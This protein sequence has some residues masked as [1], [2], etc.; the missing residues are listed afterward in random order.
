MRQGRKTLVGL[1]F[2]AA[3]GLGSLLLLQSVALTVPVKHAGFSHAQHFSKGLSQDCG[4]CHG[5]DGKGAL[6]PPGQNHAPCNSCHAEE[7]AKPNSKLCQSCHTDANPWEKDKP[8]KPLTGG[9]SS[10]VAGFSHKD[11]TD[12]IPSLKE[13]DCSSC[14]PTQAGQPAK[15][16]PARRIKD[17]AYTPAAHAQCS[18]CHKNLE[19]KMDNCAG[20]HRA[21]EGGGEAAQKAGNPMMW[22]VGAKFTHD[23]H[24]KR[25]MKC[26]NCHQGVMDVAAGK[27][28]PRPTKKGCEGCHNGETAFGV[29]GHDCAR[30]HGPN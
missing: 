15:A 25:G 17:G 4:A 26:D 24:G 18:S 30:C 21:P 5:G 27:P 7:F 22:R 20:C 29:T 28:A 11:H 14:H 9:V 1:V 23:E 19:P 2:G 12:R 10:F 6:M 8:I 13:G 16:A 3:V